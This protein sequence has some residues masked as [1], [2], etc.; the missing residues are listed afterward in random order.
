MDLLSTQLPLDSREDNLKHNFNLI[1]LGFRSTVETHIALESSGGQPMTVR[2]AIQTLDRSRSGGQ[3][4]ARVLVCY[5]GSAPYVQID[6]FVLGPLKICEVR[7]CKDLDHITADQ[8]DLVLVDIRMCDRE[9][10]TVAFSK[11]RQHNVCLVA[12]CPAIDASPGFDDLDWDGVVVSTGGQAQISALYCAFRQWRA[13]KELEQRV[14]ELDQKLEETRV[15]GRAKAIMAEQLGVS[16]RT[17]LD[18]LRR[19]ARKR[20]KPMHEL[21]E[22]IINAQEIISPKADSV[23]QC[24]TTAPSEK[25][26]R[27]RPLSP[28]LNRQQS[29]GPNRVVAPITS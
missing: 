29:T 13:R 19:E 23:V 8:L 16:E 14:A 7:S 15:V 27:S 4:Q 20:R 9:C 1:G 11:L 24:R 21:A 10:L 18:Q 12:L 25:P 26:P 5:F 2:A 28:H 6:E 3:C 22:V 17:A